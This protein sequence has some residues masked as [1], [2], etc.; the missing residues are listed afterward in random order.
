[1]PPPSHQ[2]PKRIVTRMLHV[3][4]HPDKTSPVQRLAA[5]LNDE[6]HSATIFPAASVSGR[7]AEA[8]LDARQL[9]AARRLAGVVSTAL[10]AFAALHL[11]S[12]GISPHSAKARRA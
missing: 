12:C 6:G 5:A 1:M 10:A 2:S 8:R 3:A 11:E 4:A 7:A 9:R